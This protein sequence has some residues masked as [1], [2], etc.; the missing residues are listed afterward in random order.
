MSLASLADR[1][2][3]RLQPG[4]TRAERD[5]E[6]RFHV[7][8]HAG[9]LEADG[10]APAEARRR[11]M[12]AF[13]GRERFQEEARDARGGRWLEDLARDLRL[14]LRGLRRAPAYALTVVLSLGL[15]LGATTAVAALAYGVLL[16][17]LPHGEPERLV[18]LRH[19]APGFGVVDG[20]QS[21]GTFQHYRSNARSFETAGVYFDRVLSLT[22]G[23]RA[24]RVQGVLATPGVLAALGARAHLGRTFAEGDGAGGPP[25]I[26]MLSHAL[27]MQRYGGDPAILERTIEVNRAP[28]RVV[29]VLP[30]DFAFPSA[31]AQLWFAW[32][33]EEAERSGVRDL[34]M[35][36]VARLRRGVSPERAEAELR[37]LVPGLA[38]AYPDVTA[39]EL[40]AA[41]FRPVVVPLREAM[42][43]DVRPALL[44][45]LGTVAFVL[46]A[47]WANVTNLSIVRA[48]RRRREVAVA[49]ALGASTSRVVRRELAESGLLALAGLAVALPLAQALTAVRF[50]FGAGELPRLHEVRVDGPALLVAV[51]LSAASAALLVLAALAGARRAGPDALRATSRTTTSAGARRARRALVGAQVALSLLLLV[52]AAVMG[53][54][55]RN[56]QRAE[57]GF[58]PANVLA[59]D[60]ALPRREYETYERGAAFYA[61]VLA[62]LRRVPGVRSAAAASALPLGHVEEFMV[63][64]V[65]PADGDAPQRVRR[66]TVVLATPGYLAAMRTPLL[67]GRTFH[68]ADLI[69]EAPGVILGASS[70]RALFGTTDAVGRRLRVDA[71]DRAHLVVGVAADVPGPT[72]AGGPADVLY[73]PMLDTVPAA[74][75]LGE[76]ALRWPDELTVVVRTSVPPERV[77]ADARRIVAAIDPKVPVARVRTLSDVVHRATARARLTAAL[78]AV[79]AGTALALGVLGIYGVVA[80]AAS[81]RA[82][83]LGIRM[84]L[85]ATP[86]TVRRLVLREGLGVAAVGVLLGLAAAGGLA[87]LLQGLAYGVRP[88]DPLTFGAAAALLLLVATLASW[89]PARRA[90]RMD[91]T[92]ALRAD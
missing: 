92:V 64:P 15:G 34:Y 86:A 49:R 7:E 24:E 90:A 54:S 89:I 61:D 50:G 41:R 14:S 78:L 51:A 9:R 74:R 26:V 71:G 91:P 63:S 10:V 17:P 29:G 70:A 38:A 72:I 66:A 8:M 40:A 44:L 81:L 12:I 73:A 31:E 35:T 18:T 6:F 83:E 88:T 57:L 30:P 80:Y 68:A 45:V 27:W 77:V 22:D 82:P 53:R 33:L 46:L 43:R 85:G 3:R 21:D 62:R 39:A 2:R 47:T 36:G 69:G 84:A 11:A 4:A 37:A 13:G 25:R 60:L 1:L 23:E 65:R 5:E 20:G 56:L 48:E 67:H 32:S 55:L 59:F 19:A 28:A 75:D 52:G 42:V 87:R 58:V 79:A 16:R 76:R